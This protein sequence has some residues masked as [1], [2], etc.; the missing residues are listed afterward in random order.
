M[1]ELR[2]WSKPIAIVAAIG[3]GLLTIAGFFP[4]SERVFYL[5][6]AM[7]VILP[8]LWFAFARD[9]FEGVPIGDKIAQRQ[10]MIAEIEA[11]YKD[12]AAD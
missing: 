4:P 2:L 11:K 3:V 8:I 6:V 9:R 12:S 10:T 7:V 5:T 1:I